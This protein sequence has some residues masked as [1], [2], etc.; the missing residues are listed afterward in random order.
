MQNSAVD[1]TKELIRCPSLTPN[2]AKCQEIISRRLA[3]LG[4]Q[5]EQLVFGDVTN[6]WARYG[7]SSPVLAFVGHTDV[8]PCGPKTDWLSDPF[9]PEIRNGYLF[10]RGASDMK[11]AIAAM[12]IAVES[13]IKQHRS[14]PGSIAFLLTSDEE[15][16]SID[17]TKKV[18]EVL[19]AR[20]EK[21]DYCIVGEP[22]SNKQVGDQIRIGR[23]GSLHGKL[24]IYGKQGHVAYPSLAQNPIHSSLLALH[25]LA[26]VVWDHGN[27][28]FP[29][30]SF[31]I[32]NIQSGTGAANVIPGH[33]TCAINFRYSTAISIE[34]LQERT[35]AILS[36]LP[37]RYEIE[38]QVGAEPFVTR[39]GKLLTIAQETI[40]ELAGLTVTLSTAGGTSDARFIAPTGA[41]IIELGVSHATAHQVNESVCIEDLD[42]LVK[43]YQHIIEKLFG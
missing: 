36:K 38:W 31:Q 23:R 41:E 25:E 8:V 33:L 6:L 30:T 15:G 37:L 29:P 22:S 1:L 11:S 20:G 14:F 32:S 4:F 40:K 27:D 21:I 35:Q 17:G 28:D 7:R 19:Q 13:F 24:T 26:N 43:L 16:P 5:C 10:G 12:I 34:Q 2:D 3:D 39:K 9:L 18:M 42:L